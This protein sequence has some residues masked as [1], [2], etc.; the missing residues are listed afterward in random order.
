MPKL[1]TPNTWV[2]EVLSG[3]E[4]YDIE[5]NGGTPIETNV[6]INLATSVAVAGSPVNAARMNNIENGIDDLDDALVAGNA[7]N[8]HAL[9]TKSTP[10]NSD[11][12]KI[13][14]SAASYV[15]KIVTLTNLWT[16]YL[17]AKAD[18]L[19]Q[20]LDSDLTAI[21]GLSPSNDDIIQ[22][23]SSA[24]TNRTMAQLASDLSSPLYSY[25]I[26]LNGW[27]PITAT[28]TR[29]GNYTFTVSGDVTATY[30]K[31]AKIRYKDG[32]A[33]EYGVIGNS[34][35]SAP[36]TTITLIE[37]SDYAM[38][39]ATITDKYIS[40]T[41]TPEGFP[42]WFNWAPTLSGFS[43]NPSGGIYRWKAYGQSIKCFV[44]QPNTGTSNATTFTISAPIAAATITNMQWGNLAAVTDNGTFLTTPGAVRIISAAVDIEVFE[45]SALGAFTASGTKRVYSAN[46]DYQF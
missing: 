16:N 26:P 6:Q 35:Y 42:D 11:E 3:A 8:E 45:D 25:L 46:I 37:N 38:A 39:S 5:T 13:F 44:R 34:T 2:D 30:R 20:A 28:W 40:Y 27:I 29:T 4:R 23:K 10:A 14:D 24:W 19:Y 22:R 31:G 1:Y 36:N 17:K 32:G 12:I 43:A 41:E 21:A 9:T 15:A 33:Y 18:A 7:T